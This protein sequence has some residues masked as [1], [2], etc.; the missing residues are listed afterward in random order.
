MSGLHWAGLWES[1][2]LI[3][4]AF[5]EKVGKQ[6]RDIE[7]GNNDL[8]SAWCTQQGDLLF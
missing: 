1:P 8:K 2:E 7:H 4:A 5:G 3:E 6:P